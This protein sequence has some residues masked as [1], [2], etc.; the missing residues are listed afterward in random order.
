VRQ[1]SPDVALFPHTDALTR[2][3]RELV[4][5][6]GIRVVEGVVA[7]LVVDNDQL[8]GVEL[9]DGTV[10]ARTAVFVRP[11]FVPNADLLTGWAVRWMPTAGWSTTR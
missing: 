3:Q 7:R 11:R 5:A 8:H 4:A 10:V 6:R 1:W 2:E 9:R